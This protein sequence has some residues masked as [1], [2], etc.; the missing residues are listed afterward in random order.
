VIDGRLELVESQFILNEKKQ[1]EKTSDSNGK[2]ND[3]YGGEHFITDDISDRD[4]EVIS[5]HWLG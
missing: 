2:A 4:E 5:D 3:V 1:C